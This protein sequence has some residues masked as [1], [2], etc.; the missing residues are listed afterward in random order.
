MNQLI[1]EVELGIF[2][3]SHTSF[4]YNL[5]S[6]HVVWRQIVKKEIEENDKVISTIVCQFLHQ[7]AGAKQTTGNKDTP[8][9][10]KIVFIYISIW[11]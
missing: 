3:Q 6:L 1:G 2:F 7:Q 11:W 10:S 4:A 8:H 9:I 5:L